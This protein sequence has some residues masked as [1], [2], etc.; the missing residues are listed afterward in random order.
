MGAMVSPDRVTVYR[1]TG[2]PEPFGNRAEGHIAPQ[3]LLNVESHLRGEGAHLA[4]PGH[5][6]PPTEWLEV[7]TDHRVQALRLRP[8][9]CRES[10]GEQRGEVPDLSVRRGR[11]CPGLGSLHDKRFG[12]L[13]R[14]PPPA[15]PAVTY[16]APVLPGDRGALKG[17]VLVVLGNPPESGG[18]RT[19]RRV[20][21]LASLLELEVIRANLFAMP[22]RDTTG[23]AAL[24]AGP[25]GWAAARGE[26]SSKLDQ[27]SAVVHAFGV[28]APTG[29]AR[30]LHRQQVAW[31]RAECQARGLPEWQ[32]GDGPR[33][34]SRWQRWTARV[35]PNEP[36]ASALVRSLQPAPTFRH[37]GAPT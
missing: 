17:P 9:H 29:P 1:T 22:S 34:P 8:I 19:T 21:L 2:L 27:A 35:H 30:E 3:L 33:H 37:Y 10:P 36:F 12:R 14:Q 20:E 25:A 15:P 26:L 16:A 18:L 32:V 5:R 28:T 6:L 31:L 11:N 13:A 7:S 4:L 24:G 23:V